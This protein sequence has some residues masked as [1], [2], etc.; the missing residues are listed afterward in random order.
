MYTCRR[1]GARIDIDIYV[2]M[3]YIL[4]R[5]DT[6]GGGGRFETFIREKEGRI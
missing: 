5:I 3:Q 1:R 2:Y 6:K 4:Y